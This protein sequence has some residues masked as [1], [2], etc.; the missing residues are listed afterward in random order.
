MS[1]IAPKFTDKPKIKQ[2]GKNVV[3][4]CTLTADPIGEISWSKE[5]TAIASGGRYKAGVQS[6]GTN[7]TLTLEISQINAQ[8]GGDYAVLAKNAFGESSASIKLNL[9]TK[10]QPPKA[11]KFPNK[12][13]IRKDKDTNEI[14][15]SCLL[16]G[17]PKPEL[18]F[19]LADKAIEEKPGK[20]TFVVT[21][22]SEDNYTVEIR[23][24]SPTPEDG[25]NY[26]I[27]AKN[28]AGESNAS[29]SL[30]LQAKEKTGDQPPAFEP[31]SI[32]KDGKAVVI[33]CRC[34]AK[35]APTFKWLKGSLEVRPRVGKYE[36]KSTKD[37]AVYVEVL[38][39]LNFASIDA[40]SY[41]LVAKNSG[42]EAKATNVLKFPKVIGKPN[43]TYS[44]NNKK[45][46]IE[47]K[48]ESSEAC[49]VTWKKGA[50]LLKDGGRFTIK[51]TQEEGT[52][53]AVLTIDQLTE[54][55]N[56]IYD[57]E[58]TNS[59]GS[60]KATG[61]IK[62]QEYETEGPQKSSIPKL[63]SKP[64]NKTAEPGSTVI[65]KLGYNGGTT[66]PVVKFLKRGLDVTTD[67]RAVVRVDTF[68]KTVSMTLR[69][70]KAEDQ[71]LYTVQLLSGGKVCDTA[72]FSLNVEKK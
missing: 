51:N 48:C 70:V 71:A 28:A 29:I 11:P 55:D 42:G 66:A 69:S 53:V 50:T 6:S 36:R 33:E 10:A 68:G 13:E 12:P 18:T 4:E 39:I 40:D 60:V 52:A 41:I 67:S 65:I 61:S 24:A 25:G 5:G 20:R 2:A 30:N 37:G 47:V 15:L 38:R 17:K 7:H 22:L 63:T 46:T 57:C 9:G 16:E 49:T 43:I 44:E 56:G 72:S 26:R 35:P 14:V 34:T 19:Y 58:F 59:F 45:A 3:F 8:D 54:A 64:E 32:R 62:V 21:P 1:G 23:I 27:N 31:S